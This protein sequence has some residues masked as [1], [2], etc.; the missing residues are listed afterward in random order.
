MA[1]DNFDDDD[2]EFSEV[3]DNLDPDT[4]YW[5][6]ACYED[7]DGDE[8]CADVESFTT[9]SEDDDTDEPEDTP[10][11]ATPTVVT[12]VVTSVTGSTAR[13]NG[14][15]S[16]DGNTAATAWFEWG[17]TN[18][19]GFRTADQYLGIG[20][21]KAFA[22][23]IF[24]LTANTTYYFRA[25]A[26]NTGGTI[27]GNVLNFRTVSTV[28]PVTPVYTG[29]TVTTVGTGGGTS[30]LM[31][32]ITSPYDNACPADIND[33]TVKYKNISGRTLTDVV[34]RVTLPADV[35]FRKSSAGDFSDTDNTL[36]V[37]LDELATNEEGEIFLSGEV[38]RGVADEDIMVA[39]AVMAYTYSTTLGQEDAIAYK[40]HDVTRCGN[41]SLAGFALFGNGF[42]PDTFGGWLLILLLIAILVAVARSISRR[43]V[44]AP[45][46]A[47]HSAAPHGAPYQARSVH[48]LPH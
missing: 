23:D 46:A 9:D 45:V 18:G 14:L 13:L 8:E 22:N 34:L 7:E 44:V 37:Q 19:L 11:Y 47:S 43:S 20:D 6:I 33:Y 10:D 29:P 35:M 38:M 24:G 26:R 12:T 2:G 31:L 42:F 48:D 3:V 39:T 41:S 1:D 36:T 40:I 16:S 30:R 28:N 32:E 15:L 5:Y 21:G 27:C 17:T 25:C 4:K